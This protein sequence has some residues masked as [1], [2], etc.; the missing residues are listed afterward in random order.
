[1]QSI[2]VVRVLIFSD[3]PHPK[4]SELSTHF[5][6]QRPVSDPSTDRVGAIMAEILD[7]ILNPLFSKHLSKAARGGVSEC[8]GSVKRLYPEMT[9]F[10]LLFYFAC[11]LI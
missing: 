7:Q 6:V 4:M 2:R 11:C 1:M 9:Q 8:L 3:N 5:Q 10:A